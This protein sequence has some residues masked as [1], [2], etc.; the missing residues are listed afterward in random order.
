M[1]LKND[2][3]KKCLWHILTTPRSDITTLEGYAL[4]GL[5][6][7]FNQSQTCPE[8][9]QPVEQATLVFYMGLLPL[10]KMSSL[11]N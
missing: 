4:R 3:G 2:H 10:C 1:E 5:L 8:P 7:A 11:F 6:T 9:G